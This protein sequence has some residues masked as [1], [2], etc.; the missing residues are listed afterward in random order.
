MK[1]IINPKLRN[2]H[3]KQLQIRLNN[4][5]INLYEKLKD[6]NIRELGISEYNQRYLGDYM[7]EYRFF[8]PDL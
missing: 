6:L 1:Y 4:S 7:R 5:A 8:Y 2:T 3:K